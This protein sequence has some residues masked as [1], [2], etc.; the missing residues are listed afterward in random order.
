MD[1]SKKLFSVSRRKKSCRLPAPPPA[2]YF[3]SAPT[4]RSSDATSSSSRVVSVAPLTARSMCGVM[5]FARPNGGCDLTVIIARASA[6]WSSRRL[7]DAARR[8]RAASSAALPRRPPSAAS[9]ARRSVMRSNSSTLPALSKPFII[10][11]PFCVI[12]LGF[13]GWFYKIPAWGRCVPVGSANIFPRPRSGRAALVA[14]AEGKDRLRLGGGH[15]RDGGVDRAR[16]T[17]GRFV[18]RPP[19]RARRAENQPLREK[20]I[21]LVGLGE[22][23]SAAGQA[24]TVGSSP[25]SAASRS[26]KTALMNSGVNRLLL[27]AYSALSSRLRISPSPSLGTT[28]A[29][30]ASQR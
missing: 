6:V 13:A 27:S 11:L 25:E 1:F 20:E 10:G 30:L 24:P 22:R 19:G 3:F 14:D 21:A 8:L 29:A 7:T 2:P 5:F 4:V 17:V 16:K 15:I 26:S 18:R 9:E 28:T 12:R 23:T